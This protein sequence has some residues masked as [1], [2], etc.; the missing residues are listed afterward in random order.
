M[1]YGGAVSTTPP[2]GLT[3]IKNDREWLRDAQRF[4][5][6]IDV[7]LALAFAWL[8]YAL[9]P[10]L[11]ESSSAGHHHASPKPDRQVA[12][13]NAI[14]NERIFAEFVGVSLAGIGVIIRSF[15]GSDAYVGFYVVSPSEI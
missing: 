15:F 3:Q 1:G 14:A 10:D 7:A 13:R 9:L 5:V 4:P 2:G 12:A 11:P 8:A 6:L